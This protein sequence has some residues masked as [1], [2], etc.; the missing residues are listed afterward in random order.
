MHLFDDDQIADF[1]SCALNSDD[2]TSCQFLVLLVVDIAVSQKPTE[3]IN[4]LTYHRYDH[5]ER[6]Q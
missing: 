1:D 5:N 4:C 6:L 2:S 3:I